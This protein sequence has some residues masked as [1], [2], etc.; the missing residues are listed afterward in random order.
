MLLYFG[1]KYLSLNKACILNRANYK[2]EA[3]GNRRISIGVNVK[4]NHQV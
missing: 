3:A 1:Q 4:G 2:L